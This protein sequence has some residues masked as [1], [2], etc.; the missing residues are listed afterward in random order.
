MKK[1]LIAEDEYITASLYKRMI[2]R[3]G[4]EVVAVVSTGE[5]AI[6]KTGELR[7]DVTLLDISMEHNTAGVDACIAIKELYPDITV[8][9]LSAYPQYAY[10]KVLEGVQYD[11]YIDK[12][13]FWETAEEW[14]I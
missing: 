9:F 1:I 10:E 8:Y 13:D 7:P 4:H 12:L 11:G 14:F 2:Q 5:E 3:L 6:K